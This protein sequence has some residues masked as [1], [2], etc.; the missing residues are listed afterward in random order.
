MNEPAPVVE[1][2]AIDPEDRLRALEHLRSTQRLVPGLIT[3]ALAALVGA[4]VWALVTV[5]TKT[6][7]GWLAIGIGA[8]VGVAVRWS[9]RGFEIRYA[10]LGAALAFAGVFVGNFL[11]IIGLISNLNGQSFFTILQSFP[12]SKLPALMQETFQPMDVLFY[13]LA[14]WCGW[15]YSRRELEDAE[16]RTTLVEMKSG[17]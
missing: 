3:G 15:K 9:G 16:I 13:A 6:Q 8:L 4:A 12:Y 10:I 7:I 1:P 14:I 17:R 5:L 2:T 11:T